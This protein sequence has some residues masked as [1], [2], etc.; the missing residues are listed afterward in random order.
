M[1]CQVGTHHGLNDCQEVRHCPEIAVCWAVWAQIECNALLGTCALTPVT[2]HPM[3]RPCRLTPR[4]QL[5]P[6]RLIFTSWKPAAL[7]HCSTLRVRPEVGP[8]EDSIVASDS[9]PR[10][11]GL[12]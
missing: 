4:Y 5:G 11:A 8:R 10:P 2:E 7:N 6:M 9:R 1:A 3:M 12:T